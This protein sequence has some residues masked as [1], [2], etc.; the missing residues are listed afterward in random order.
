MA[1]P[2]PS[3]GVAVPADVLEPPE[4]HDARHERLQDRRRERPLRQKGKRPRRPGRRRRRGGGRRQSDPGS[5]VGKHKIQ[6]NMN[7]NNLSIL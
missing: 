1:N 6:I 7:Q 3:A 4:R 5:V 2:A